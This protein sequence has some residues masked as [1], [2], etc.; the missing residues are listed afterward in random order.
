MVISLHKHNRR[1]TYKVYSPY[2]FYNSNHN[3]MLVHG[4]Y[5]NEWTILII[6][7]GGDSNDFPRARFDLH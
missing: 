1:T 4:H 5:L 6:P 3:C 7:L 2:V